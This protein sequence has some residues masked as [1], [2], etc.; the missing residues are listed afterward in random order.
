MA[1]IKHSSR[2][3]IENSTY[4]HSFLASCNEVVKVI[5]QLDAGKDDGNRRLTPDHIKLG[6]NKLD[7]HYVYVFVRSLIPCQRNKRFTNQ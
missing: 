1:D 4:G 7:V 2:R 5:G 3:N 6:D